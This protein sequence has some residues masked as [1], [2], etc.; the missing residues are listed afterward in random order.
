MDYTEQVAKEFEGE[1]GRRPTLGWSTLCPNCGYEQ[2]CPCEHC[3]KNFPQKGSPWI[4]TEGDAI[5]CSNCGIT[6]HSD[7]WLTWEM[8]C[9]NLEEKTK[10]SNT[11]KN[12]GN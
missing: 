2:E 12:R 9:V 10:P 11:I 1:V 3:Q 4:W 5:Q 7:W 6:M 8:E